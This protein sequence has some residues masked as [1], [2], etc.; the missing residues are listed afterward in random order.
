MLILTS[1]LIL[2]MVFYLKV[3]GMFLLSNSGF[4]K[5]VIIIGADMRS[6]VHVDDK[7][8]YLNSW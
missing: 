1:V 4:G 3:Q 5:N 8:R 2:N 6:S 7:K